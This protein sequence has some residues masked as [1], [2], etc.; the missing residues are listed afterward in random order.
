MASY[1]EFSAT[2]NVITSE[3]GSILHTEMYVMK[4]NAAYVCDPVKVI[5]HR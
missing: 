4:D 2:L 5:I 1:M 3:Y